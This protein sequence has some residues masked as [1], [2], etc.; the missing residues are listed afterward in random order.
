VSEDSQGMNAQGGIGGGSGDSA[1]CA[2]H[3]RENIKDDREMLH[4]RSS[5]LLDE[6]EQREMIEKEGAH[7]PLDFAQGKRKSACGRN[8]G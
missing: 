2:G 6:L 7:M 3:L 4:N 1:F 5:S 8:N